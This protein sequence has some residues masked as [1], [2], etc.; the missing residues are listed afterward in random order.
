MKNPYIVLNVS[1]EAEKNEI[2]KAQ[3]LAMKKREYSL[4]EIQIAVQQ[5]LHPVKRLAADF[6][7]PSKIKAKRIQKL[8]CELF[9]QEIDLNSISDDAF[10]S[11]K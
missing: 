7:F 1:P 4:P 5:L 11:L 3:I 10:D 9:F 2:K 8:P 6:T